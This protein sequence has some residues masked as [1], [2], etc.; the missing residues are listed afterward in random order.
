LII[1]CLSVGVS[2]YT[3]VELG[4][5]G[6][7]A[8]S[9]LDTDN[10]MIASEAI[11]T[12]AFLSEV[13]Y[14]GRFIITRAGA[15][16]DQW[17]QF[18]NDFGR[19]MSEIKSLA[20]SPEITARLSRIEELHSR[21]DDLFD[22]EV[23]Y[24]KAGQPYAE[25]RYQQEKE[26]ILESALVELGR[27]KGQLQQNLSDK[28]ETMGRAARTA[29]TIAAL[30]TLVLLGIGIALSFAISNSMTRPLADLRRRTAEET[31]DDPD[32]A[33]KLSRIPEILELSGALSD[34]RRKL[35]E[36]AETNTVFVQTV[37]EQFTTP[38]V[39][40]KKRLSYLKEELAEKITAEQRTT[41][42]ILAEETERLIQRCGALRP[43]PIVGLE[44]KK[45]QEQAAF[46]GVKEVP[47]PVTMDYW[48]TRCSGYLTH[49]ERAVISIV[50]RVRL[51][52]AGSWNAFFQSLNKRWDMER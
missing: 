25:S 28:L 27:L 33:S 21:Y 22:Q 39:S 29:R 50:A 20:A 12:D 40:L 44:A 34:A 3:V 19:Y 48:M 38:L 43:P 11:L 15:L 5:L 32:P 16:H 35:R 4:G 47:P 45:R 26:K 46:R 10:R 49:A 6:G 1:L 23:R 9:V 8:R 42:A 24:V 30:T 52:A 7:T 2:S 31:A 17:H 18:K 13:R 41:F 37:N 51:L 14:G 36:A